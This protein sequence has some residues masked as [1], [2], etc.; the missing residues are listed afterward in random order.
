M[1][2]RNPREKAV[3]CGDDVWRADIAN[4]GGG[5]PRKRASHGG[6][7]L[8][9]MVR[10][11]GLSFMADVPQLPLKEFF[12]LFQPSYALGTTYTVSLAFFEGLVFPEISRANL[13]RCL[14][15][16]DKTGFQRATVESSALR[17]A[18]REYMAICVPA[19]FAFHPKV[20]VM[21]GEDK[22]A[23]LVGSGNLTQSGFMDNT[24][25]F[26]VVQ[27]EVG[28]AFKSVAE[29]AAAFLAGLRSLWIGADSRRLLATETLDD[30]RGSLESL[31]K[32]MPDEA[33]PQARLLSNFGASLVEQL[34]QYFHGGAL[35]VAAP[36]FG[37]SIEGV[38]LLKSELS[39]ATMKVFPAVHAEAELDVP[40]AELQ[41]VPGVSVH[42]LKIAKRNSFAHLKLYG[43][44]GADEQWMF[45]TSANC[46]LAALGGDNVEAGLLR[47]VDRT[48]LDEYFAEQPN[49]ALPSAMRTGDRADAGR[50]LH[51]WAAD[52]GS[53]IELIAAP[54]ESLPVRNLTATV[55]CGGITAAQQFGEMFAQGAVDS[56]EWDAFRP[57]VDRTRHTALI[58]LTGT[59]AKGRTFSGDALIDNPLLL[60]SD[61]THRSAWRAAVALLEGE[62]LPE[63]A[64]LASIFHLVQDVFDAEDD[65]PRE[66]ERT[67][68]AGHSQG[69]SPIQDKVPIWPPIAGMDWHGSTMAGGHLHN[70][71]WFQK[72][73]AEFLNPR[74]DAT[75][76]GAASTSDSQ[77]DEVTTERERIRMPSRVVK[78]IWKQT[79]GSFEQL[80]HRLST[81]VV[82][83]NLAR[84]IWAVATAILL[85]TLLTRRQLLPHADATAEIP[86]VADVIR[87]FL[88]ML[89][90]DRLQSDDYSPASCRYRHA[91]FPAVAADL[92][93]EFNQDPPS[94][95]AGIVCLA[96]AYWHASETQA[97]RRVPSHMWLLFREIAPLAANGN[98][99]KRETLR[100]ILEKYILDESDGLSWS[101]VE[102]S[103]NSQIDTGWAEHEGYGLLDVIM[104][105]GAGGQSDGRLPPH[106]EE[107]W[108]QTKHRI[109]HGKCW[110]FAVDPLS[111]TCAADGCSGQY[112]MDP[113]KRRDL[114]KLAPTICSFCGAVLVPERLWHAYEE[115]HE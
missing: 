18:G 93:V 81:L 99:L 109:D 32:R 105:R 53:R 45:T 21:I 48:I 59:D 104:R 9:D 103:L 73:L 71:Q 12:K 34:G 46:T 94:D 22:A 41:S 1:L 23:V 66:G 70:L 106:L 84:K 107:R 33:K 112:L 39:A 19:R 50:W 114:R 98:D 24:E 97:E 8:S 80:R 11:S 60:T 90:V 25:L 47:R 68:G 82:T 44:D 43:L 15:L 14:L 54:P 101:E 42:A 10:Y 61:P 89:F 27:L 87:D 38:Q 49:A 3:E 69:K 40:I 91:A 77:D 63:S 110:R 26:D 115:R 7:Q 86:S 62:G 28:G 78:S 56:V 75:S 108:P 64:D 88:R 92:H 65:E 96:F 55:R 113:K 31:A 85:A 72:I 79:A 20:W 2:E 30:M 35:R 29:D 6:L 17:S 52:R 51:F 36:Y 100:T 74:L 5:E 16:C 83:S 76:G 13:R 37:G 102:A 4:Q 58:S 67:A 95:I 57:T 111:E